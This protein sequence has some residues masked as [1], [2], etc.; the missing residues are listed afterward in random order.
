VEHHAGYLA[1]AHRDGHGQRA[2]G[3]CCVVPLAQGEAQH[4]AGG[5]IQHRDQVQLALTCGDLGAIAEP[6]AVERGRGEVP[7]DQ[8]RRPPPAPAR[9]SCGAPLLLAPGRQAQLAHQARDGV[10]ADPPAFLT[11]I[12][13][14]PRRAVLA[15]VELEQAGDLGFEPLPPLRSRR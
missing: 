6:F 14:D 9:A 15:L 3:Q 4:P 5:H 7:L 11:Q 2:V 12:R 8:V 13:R 1:A 10:L